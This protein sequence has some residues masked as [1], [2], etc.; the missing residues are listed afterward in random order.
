MCRCHDVAM[1]GHVEIQITCGN[2][3]EA[4]AIAD[5]LVDRRFAACVQQVPIRSTYRWK[6]RV[7]HD[8]EIL[9]LVKTTRRRYESVEAAV[10]EIHSYEVPAI[11]CVDIAAGSTQYLAWLDNETSTASE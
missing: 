6:G 11:S 8:E 1:A 9:L 4:D 10:L 7:E 5:A 3:G 2:Q